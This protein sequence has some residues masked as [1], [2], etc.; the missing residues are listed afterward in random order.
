[1]DKAA[2]VEDDINAG[3]TLVRQLEEDG[4]PITAA[5]WLKMPED[6]TWQLYIATPEVESRGPISVYLLIDRALKK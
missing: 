3:Q 1:V 4:L 2:L 5:L 6:P